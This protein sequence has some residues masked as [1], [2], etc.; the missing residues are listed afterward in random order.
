MKFKSKLVSF[1]TSAMC[2]LSAF[3]VM[4]AGVWAEEGTYGVLTYEKT[5]A[6]ADGTFDYITITGCDETATEV[7]VPSEIEGLAV[8]SIGEESF[9]DCV[10]LENVEISEGIKTIE[11]NA[12][13][14]CTSLESINLPNSIEKLEPYA[15]THCEA[16]KSIKI[17]DKITRIYELTFFFCTSLKSVE[18]PENLMQIDGGAFE[19]CFSLENIEIPKSV[20]EIKIGAFHACTALKN[21]TIY[22]SDCKIYD[23]AATICNDSNWNIETQEQTCIFDGTIHGYINSTAQT[24]AEKYGYNFIALDEN[25][26]I[27]K[28]DVN[29]NGTINLYDVIEVAKYIL[30]MTSFDSEQLSLG[31]MNSDGV[32]N[33]YDA[34][35]IAEIIME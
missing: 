8:E 21:I 9:V 6:D 25:I 1:I 5:D 24:Y 29:R 14:Y 4:P 15:F 34:I 33:L 32:V 20:K 17:P 28:G 3:S 7:T 31:D 35:E 18:L 27:S 22:N 19:Y 12:F 16:L 23:N 11:K 2:A 10:N 13:S 30:N 26:V